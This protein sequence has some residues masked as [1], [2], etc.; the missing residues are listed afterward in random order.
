MDPLLVLQKQF[1][2]K[3]ICDEI[4]TDNESNKLKQKQKKGLGSSKFPKIK[5]QY[6][7]P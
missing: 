2:F 3:I 5:L 6:N 7:Q 1:F 4:K